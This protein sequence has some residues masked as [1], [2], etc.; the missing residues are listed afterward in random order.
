MYT[1]PIYLSITAYTLGRLYTDRLVLYYLKHF[2]DDNAKI[3]SIYIPKKLVPPLF[4]LI[5]R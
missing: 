1:C 5:H 2:F 4:P 3:I